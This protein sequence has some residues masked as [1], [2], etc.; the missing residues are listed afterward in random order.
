VIGNRASQVEQALACGG[1]VGDVVRVTP[2]ACGEPS[3]ALNEFLKR[4]SHN[5]FLIVGEHRTYHGNPL[6]VLGCNA[7]R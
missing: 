4:H 6:G 7:M 5:A 2:V 1:P 3:A